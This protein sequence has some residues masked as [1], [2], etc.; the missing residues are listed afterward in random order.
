MYGQVR[1]YRACMTIPEAYS[2]AYQAL[3]DGLEADPQ[4]RACLHDSDEGSA[5]AEAAGRAVSAILMLT[6]PSAPRYVAARSDETTTL[7]AYVFADET[8]VRVNVHPPLPSDPQKREV[9]VNAVPL[10]VENLSVTS[11]VTPWEPAL[12]A[13]AQW[14][15]H[16]TAV[17]KLAGLP[18]P[19][20][21]PARRA[22]NQAGRD[23]AWAL[24]R[25]LATRLNA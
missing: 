9:E 8:V 18:E 4:W 22:Q 13:S 14:P 6:G 1:L 20:S 7:H 25:H 12:G 19:I 17:I 10:R 24:V 3:I 15:G 2:A 11:S 21:I 16:V 23:A 5:A